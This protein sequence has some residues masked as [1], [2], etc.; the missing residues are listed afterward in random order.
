MANSIFNLQ[1]YPIDNLH[2]NA[3][4]KLLSSVREQLDQQGSCTL[5]DFVCD[6]ALSRMANQAMSLVDLA[7]AGPTEVSPY[8][9]NY[10]IADGFDDT[11]DH[12][13]HYKGKRNLRQVAA[14]LIP[15][16]HLLSELYH[17]TLMTDF[18]GAVLNKPVYR[19]QD[20]YQSLNISVMDLSLIHI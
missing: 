6:D 9:F 16:D 7:Y 2:S 1:K 15:P 10:A 17:S 13:V 19:N 3:A 5:P 14:D 4:G 11:D 20:K 8:F 12:P 18:L